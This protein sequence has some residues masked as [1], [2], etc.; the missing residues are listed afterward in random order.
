[1]FV[2]YLMDSANI[3]VY[4]N[5]FSISL[6]FLAFKIFLAFYW[7]FCIISYF[8]LYHM[9]SYFIYVYNIMRTIYYKAGVL[10][11][12]NSIILMPNIIEFLKQKNNILFFNKISQP[13]SN[14]HSKIFH[15]FNAT[16]WST[17]VFYLSL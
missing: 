1:M 5:R 4:R 11:A 17:F 12:G 6:H 9:P 13:L 2:S 3:N 10:K 16:F 14:R 15:K 7:C 8:Q